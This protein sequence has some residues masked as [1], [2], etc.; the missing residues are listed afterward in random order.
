M[1]DKKHQ[2]NRIEVSPKNKAFTF[3]AIAIFAII[4]SM[5]ALASI[6][7]KEPSTNQL[8]L[9]TAD[10]E[11]VRI[12]GSGSVGIGISSPASTLS[13][14]GII[15]STTG[16]IKFP[17]GSVQTTAHVVQLLYTG[18]A[19]GSTS[20]AGTS[21]S[22]ATLND[23]D[24]TTAFGSSTNA[25]NQFLEAQFAT[26]TTIYS[27]TVAGGDLSSQPWASGIANYL[28]GAT[29][30]Y[31]D[32]LSGPWT[33]INL[34]TSDGKV[35]GVTDTGTNRTMTFTLSS[36]TTAKYWRL[37]NTAATG[38]IATSEFRFSSLPSSLY[39]QSSG[40]S[41]Y[42][43]VSVNS[44]IITDSVIYQSASNIGVGTNSPSNT[45]QVNGTVNVTYLIITNNT[46][47]SCDLKA[48]TKGNVYCGTDA[49]GSGADGTGGWLNTSTYTTT[50]LQINVTNSTG[51]SVLYIN[52]TSG[53]IGM[54]TTNPTARLTVGANSSANEAI[55][56]DS[57]GFAVLRLYGDTDN[58]GSEVGAAYIALSQDG[59]QDDV[60]YNL[61]TIQ[62][63]GQN[64]AGSSY[65]G[66]IGN[67]LAMTT[68]NSN[69]IQFG[70]GQAIRMTID[71]TGNVGIGTASPGFKL[72]VNGTLAPTGH[73]TGAG[74]LGNS[75][76]YWNNTLTN[77]LEVYNGGTNQLSVSANVLSI[78]TNRFYV[79]SGGNVGIGTS[80][81]SNTLQVNGTANVTYLVIANNTASNCDLKADTRGNVYCGTDVD[82]NSGGTVTGTGTGGYITQFQS[83]SAINSSVI[84]QN[85][86]FIGINIT[87]PAEVFHVNGKIRA[88]TSFVLNGATALSVSSANT[89]GIAQSSGWSN[90]VVIYT[91][92]TEK[93]RI[94]VNGSV[95]IGTSNPTY[96][97]DVN[98]SINLPTGS[99]Y[100]SE[101]ISLIG[102]ETGTVAIGTT[103]NYNVT[104]YAGSATPRLK[105]SANGN[106][107][108]GIGTNNPQGQL[109]IYNATNLRD[110]WHS[111]LE[112]QSTGMSNYPS[113]FFSGQNSSGYS[114][115]TWTNSTS[116]GNTSMITGSIYVFPSNSTN[117]NMY[118]AT[119]GAIGTAAYTNK[120]VILGNGRV[121]IGTITP[122]GLLEVNG[123]ITATAYYYSS[124]ERL[125]DNITT[126]TGLAIV[127]KLRGVSFDWKEDGSSSIGVV[128][129]EVEK[130][131]P[132][133]VSTN[134]YTGMKSVNYGAL[135]GPLIESAKELE[136]QNIKQEAELQQLRKELQEL[137]S[138][139]R[140]IQKQ[141]GSR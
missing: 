62:T 127:D 16:G 31:A 35:R 120:M 100:R 108:I 48:D 111:A 4:L 88:D 74:S 138:D 37:N 43:P 11:W 67:A 114:S 5:P 87:T 101:G 7:I 41:G 20:Y 90:G 82:T 76:N 57:R 65:A 106:G 24:T 39:V 40:S 83:A 133:V 109:H 52:T 42:I 86:T 117:A 123:N 122:S 14:A 112:I 9:Y 85:G 1:K 136:Q 132:E 59:G 17:D 134:S 97:L 129:Q 69:P 28:N 78:G 128:A 75:T 107:S 81:P 27:I 29:L 98:G 91:N 58:D 110:G 118:F 19:T 84:Y 89:L 49:T 116:G 68:W 80:N 63:A 73:L 131:L 55:R 92:G 8:G 21:Y 12:N 95:G 79:A 30:F 94:D 6:S 45:L 22:Y 47:A 3:L 93:V 18:N 103:Q 141:G 70:T 137:K 54:G 25:G 119:N 121:G 23:Y 125:K 34:T 124:D 26:S 46:A 60:G 104:I 53:N 61:G 50:T 2:T 51:G 77:Q 66:T 102:L 33:L 135:V 126:L 96:K 140:K 36:P 130:V 15:Q 10:T 38:W 72:E 115:I 99:Y 32:S 71:A 64:P 113:I 105:I 139:L 44:S 13:V 56:I